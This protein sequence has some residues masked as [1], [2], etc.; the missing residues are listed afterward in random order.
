MLFNGFCIAISCFGVSMAYSKLKGKVIL[1]QE[2]VTTFFFTF[3][4]SWESEQRISSWSWH[5]S[6]SMMLFNGFRPGSATNP[7]VMRETLIFWSHKRNFGEIPSFVLLESED[8]HAINP[9]CLRSGRKQ[10]WGFIAKGGG[11]IAW[12]SSDLNLSIRISTLIS[13]CLSIMCWM[14][15][16]LFL[17]FNQNQPTCCD[18]QRN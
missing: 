6:V 7:I 17:R 2:H 16:T 12:I 11:V 13:S 14:N 8:I 1:S 4:A 5:F 9:P 18:N 3:W 15:P 10:G